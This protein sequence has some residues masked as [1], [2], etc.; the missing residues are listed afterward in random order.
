[1]E[2]DYNYERKEIIDDMPK[3]TLQHKE[4]IISIIKDIIIKSIERTIIHKI[5]QIQG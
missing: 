2:K 4:E 5:I 3:Q 1:M